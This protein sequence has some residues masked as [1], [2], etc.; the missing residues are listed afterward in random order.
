MERIM[1]KISL[2]VVSAAL[3]V[4]MAAP[5]SA[6]AGGPEVIIYRFPGV[7]D[8]GGAAGTGVATVFHCTNFSG[9]TETIRL[10]TRG[11]VGDLLTNV[12]VDV[13][14]LFTFSATTHTSLF[15]AANPLNT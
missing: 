5:A 1:T 15:Y 12:S 2:A 3:A 13:P 7:R 10:V 14:H 4:G 8:S 11:Q 9:A 6:A